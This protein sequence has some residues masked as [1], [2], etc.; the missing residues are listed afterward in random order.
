MPDAGSLRS[1]RGN[2]ALAGLF[3]GPGLVATSQQAGAVARALP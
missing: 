2:D 1:F 3:L